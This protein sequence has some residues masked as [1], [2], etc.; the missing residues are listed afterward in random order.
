[1]SS[2]LPPDWLT[3]GSIKWSGDGSTYDTRSNEKLPVLSQ[4][5]TYALHIAS[6][7]GASLSIIAGMVAMFWFVR[8]KRS[9][10]H[11]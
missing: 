7:A 6:V 8:M 11:E 2:Y 5:Q 1:M 3:P 9:F 4:Q 10:R